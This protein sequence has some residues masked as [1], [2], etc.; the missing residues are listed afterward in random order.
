MEILKLQRMINIFSDCIFTAVN[1]QNQRL[2]QQAQE[3]MSVMTG[4]GLIVIPLILLSSLLSFLAI[5]TAK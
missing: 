4:P 3:V 5:N 1:H 2:V